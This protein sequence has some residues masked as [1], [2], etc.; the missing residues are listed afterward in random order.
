MFFEADALSFARAEQLIACVFGGSI[1][2]IS[3]N[4]WHNVLFPVLGRGSAS[5][6]TLLKQLLL[7][8]E[9]F[10]PRVGEVKW[11]PGGFPQGEG[12]FS[13]GEQEKEK[14]LRKQRKASPAHNDRLTVMDSGAFSSLHV[15]V[16][17]TWCRVKRC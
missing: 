2:L 10:M 16:S 17:Q 11:D 8:S 12:L 6:A 4:R 5:Y 7:E 14:G 1:Y 3:V 15:N 9:P 13:A